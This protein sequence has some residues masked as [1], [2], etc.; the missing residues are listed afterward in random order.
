MLN[1]TGGT[2][3]HGGMTDCPRFP[4]SELHLG[5]FQSWKAS[6]DDLMTSRSITGLATTCL[7]R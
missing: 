2:Y 5:K 1:H 7:M 3:S 6:I 4:I